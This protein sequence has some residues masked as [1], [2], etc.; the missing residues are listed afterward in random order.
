MLLFAVICVLYS[1]LS[2]VSFR[3]GFVVQNRTGVRIAR[4]PGGDVYKRQA[5]RERASHS[6]LVRFPFFRLALDF[7]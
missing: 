5:L 1:C 2:L 4:E 6:T 3:S 7:T